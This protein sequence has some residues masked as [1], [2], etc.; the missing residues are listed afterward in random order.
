M[1]KYIDKDKQD[2]MINPFSDIDII[3]KQD[4][5]IQGNP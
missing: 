4:P 2:I 3:I 1:Y 5:T